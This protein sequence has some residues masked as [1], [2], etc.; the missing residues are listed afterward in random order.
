MIKITG[1]NQE[2]VFTN[3]DFDSNMLTN[4]EPDASR[5]Y[6]TYLEQCSEA[7][8]SDYLS[9]YAENSKCAGAIGTFVFLSCSLLPRY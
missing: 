3:I 5:Y 2:C 4:Q 1:V 7:G 9:E 6:L 8:L